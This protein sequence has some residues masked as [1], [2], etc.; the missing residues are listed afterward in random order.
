MTD[1]VDDDWYVFY[2]NRVCDD[3]NLTAN[4]ACT[5][6]HFMY[7][8]AAVKTNGGNGNVFSKWVLAHELGHAIHNHGRGEINR[9]FDAVT[10]STTFCRCEHVTVANQRHCLQSAETSSTAQSEGFGHFA[11]AKIWNHATGNDC[12]FTYYKDF[13]YPDGRGGYQ[14]QKPPNVT[15]CRTAVQWRDNQC[16]GATWGTEYD[17]MQFFWNT[18]TVGADTSSMQDLFAI[19]QIACNGSPTTKCAGEAVAWD[20][21]LQAAET[22]HGIG[23]A[24]WLVFKDNGDDYSVDHDKF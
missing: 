20:D 12:V 17:W 9:A 18:N 1:V 5:Q 15:D 23:S 16:F 13:R 4:D 19:Y 22:Y 2:V 8:G 3:P 6:S 24:K 10:S 7:T 14:D 21:L 11:A